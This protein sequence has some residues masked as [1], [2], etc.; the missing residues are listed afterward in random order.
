MAEFPPPGW[1]DGYEPPR[2][3]LIPP[4]PDGPPPPAEPPAALGILARLPRIELTADEQIRIAALNALAVFATGAS[5]TPDRAA[6]QTGVFEH[7]IRT[8]EWMHP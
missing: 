2:A 6:G 8:G 5:L 7:Y 3:G 1:P 4:A